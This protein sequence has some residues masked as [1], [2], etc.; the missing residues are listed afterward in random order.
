MTKL[1]TNWNKLRADPAYVEATR[2]LCQ[3]SFRR[4]IELSFRFVYRK[5][6]I[7]AQH[8]EEIAHELLL[9]WAGKEQNLILNVPPR[10]SKTEML[11]LFVAWSY[12]HNP[13]CE[14]LHLSYSDKLAIRNSDKVRQLMKSRFYQDIFDVEMDPLSDSKAE[15]RTMAGGVFYA[16]ATGGQ[17]TGF[18]AGATDSTEFSGAILIDDPLKPDDAYSETVRKFIN[19][20]WDATIKSRR[21]DPSRTPTICIMQRLHEDDFTAELKS[22]EDEKFKHVAMSAIRPDGTALWPAKHTVE[23]LAALKARSIY[24]YS[25]QYDQKP[26]PEGGGVFKRIWFRQWEV[27]PDYFERVVA[28]ADT[29][30]ETKKANDFSAF[31]LWGLHKQK[32]YLLDQV[33]GKWES[34][35]LLT[36][37]TRAISRWQKEYPSLS[38]LKIEKAAVAIGFIQTLRRQIPVPIIPINRSKDKVSRAYSTAPFVQSGMVLFPPDRFGFAKL[39]MDEVESFTTND[40]HANDD[41]C[42]PMFDAVSE[43][44]IKPEVAG[45]LP[46]GGGR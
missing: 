37:A 7:W 28:F 46:L 4:F 13:A 40:S 12:G 27:L 44:F 3:V 16:T 39:F 6:F 18:G 2:E 36:T 33:R 9:I 32:A 24:V 35:E 10:Y 8:H 11:M 19:Q 42:D 5:R 26:T 22:D 38:A 14:F 1:E 31:Q 41:Q 25:A 17:V 15:W 34:P 30:G 45:T 21:N 43:F 29:A 23:K 20:R